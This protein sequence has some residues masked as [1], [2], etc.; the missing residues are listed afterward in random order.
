[1]SKLGFEP[2]LSEKQCGPQ[3]F[4]LHHLTTNACFG[5]HGQITII[6]TYYQNGIDL[7][8]QHGMSDHVPISK[9][10]IIYNLKGTMATLL[11]Y[12]TQNCN[13]NKAFWSKNNCYLLHCMSNNYVPLITQNYLP[14]YHKFQNG[15][16]DTNLNLDPWLP[17]TISLVTITTETQVS[18]WKF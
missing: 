10:S 14:C 4:D 17:K 3:A 6:T 2:R 15:S 9:I 11:Y 18:K 16:F 5:K 13:L 7:L 1:M 12:N 8:K